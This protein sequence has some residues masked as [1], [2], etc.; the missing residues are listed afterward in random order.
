MNLMHL[1]AKR[2]ANLVIG[3]GVTPVK[4]K[5]NGR[6]YSGMA[7]PPGPD[8]EIRLKT[9]FRWYPFCMRP[10]SP[11]WLVMVEGKTSGNIDGDGSP[12][13]PCLRAALAGPDGRTHSQ[14]NDVASP[15][16]GPVHLPYL[17]EPL[18]QE[19]MHSLDWP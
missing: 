11:D 9:V 6:V 4:L 19:A 3:A 8:G 13:A 15:T 12:T 16:P 14:L 1:L 17:D 5:F 18:S 7:M 2:D 10:A